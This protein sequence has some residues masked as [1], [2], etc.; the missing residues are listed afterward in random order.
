MEQD[1]ADRLHQGLIRSFAALFGRIEDA[2]LED[3]EGYRLVVCPRVPVP[4]FN[5]IWADGADEPAVHE[6][7]RA[8]AEVEGLG[9]PCWIE[10]RAGRTPAVEQAARRLGFTHEDSIP[11]MV[12]RPAEIAVVPGPELEVTRVRDAAGLAVAGT[13]AAAGFE[14]PPDLF[15]AFFTSHVAAMPGLSIYVA[16]AQGRPV[17]TAT[18]WVGDG[19]IGIFSVATPP[20]HRG[21]GYG[22]AITARAVEAGFASG[23]DLAWLQASPL[24]EP[25]YRAMGFRQV[26]TY[27]IL[28]RPSDA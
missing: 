9:G 15:A 1:E 8:I 13:V 20:E 19:G 25:V 11:G 12:V 24:G 21:R 14:V 3:R 26:E 18:A 5:G 16:H 22:S 2:R 23:A 28:G 17:S 27:L 4:G 10:V 6:L 7:E